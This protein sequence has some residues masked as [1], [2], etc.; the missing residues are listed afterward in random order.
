MVEINQ[1]YI[2]M[3][4]KSKVCQRFK[5]TEFEV[6]EMLSLK[7]SSLW[8]NQLNGWT[9]N[10]P[11]TTNPNVEKI[12]MKEVKLFL[13]AV[14]NDYKIPENQSWVSYI[15][16]KDLLSIVSQL[17]S[18]SL[19]VLS[20]W[21]PIVGQIILTNSDHLRKEWLKTLPQQ[22]KE[23]KCICKDCE[24]IVDISKKKSGA[25]S[26]EHTKYYCKKCLCWHSYG[27][28]IAEQHFEFKVTNWIKDKVTREDTIK[29]L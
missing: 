10:P 14:G 11:N 29:N 9:V 23:Q 12:I 18:N 3:A 19:M 21:I 1:K 15:A 22:V 13:D 4:I 5:V 27:T 7:E 6:A 17:R 8:F 20:P 25:C 24:T 2:E 26:I 16:I 28:K